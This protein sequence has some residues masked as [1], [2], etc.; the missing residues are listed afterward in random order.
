[1]P[2]SRSVSVPSSVTYPAPC[3]NGLIVPGSTLMYGSSFI[4]RT[5]SPRASRIAPRL[6]EVI[7]LPS[8][9]TTPPVMKMNRV[10]SKPGGPS[11]T[12][13]GSHDLALEVRCWLHPDGTAKY[14]KRLALASSVRDGLGQRRVVRP[15]DGP[16][17]LVARGARAVGYPEIAHGDEVVVSVQKRDARAHP[18]DDRRLLEPVLE[19]AVV[20]VR[21]RLEELAAAAEAQREPVV[22]PRLGQTGPRAERL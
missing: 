15:N 10:M 20:G 21:E 14:Q 3:W 16:A 2:R 6:A 11:G 17:R 19:R 1:W 12:P 4:R 22:E 8:E 13:T 18:G 7:P 9:E 5:L